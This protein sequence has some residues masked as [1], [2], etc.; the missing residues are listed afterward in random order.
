MTTTVR[1]MLDRQELARQIAVLRGRAPQ[2]AG[3]A[4]CKRGTGR[5]VA[6]EIESAAETIFGGCRRSRHEPKETTRPGRKELRRKQE[7][8]SV[9]RAL[10]QERAA[11]LC[12]ACPIRRECYDLAVKAKVTGAAAGLIMVNG[13]TYEERSRHRLAS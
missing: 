13:S 2:I 10:Y 6:L 8:L 4:P 9:Q 3:H 1:D 12:A 11:S 5:T 7:M